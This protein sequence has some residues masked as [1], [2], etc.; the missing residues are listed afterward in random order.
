MNKMRRKFTDPRLEALACAIEDTGDG[1][2][3]SGFFDYVRRVKE[4]QDESR[5]YTA[6]EYI[7]DVRL[8]CEPVASRWREAA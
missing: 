6:R 8:D 7:R 2:L 5:T 1:P 4:W 3:I